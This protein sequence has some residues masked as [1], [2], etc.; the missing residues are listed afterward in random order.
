MLFTTEKLNNT[1]AQKEISNYDAVSFQISIAMTESRSL[2][3]MD[4]LL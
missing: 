3:D 1:A 2:Q 4:F